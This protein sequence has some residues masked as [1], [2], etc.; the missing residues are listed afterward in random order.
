MLAQNAQNREARMWVAINMAAS[1]DG[2]IATKARGPVK[3]GSAQDSRRMAEIR[4]EHDAVINGASTFR[5]YPLPLSVEPRDLVD[6]RVSAG[7]SAQP[8]SAVVSS[9]LDI[10]RATKWEKAREVE[11]WI[12]CGKAAPEKVKRALESSGVRVIRSKS[13]RPSAKEILSAFTKAGCKK[14]LLEGGGEFNAAFLEKGLVN[15]I[16]LT[17]APL[18]I[19][20]AESITFFEGKGFPRGKFPRFRLQECKEMNGELFLTYDRV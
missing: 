7:R 5:A 18:L 9:R 15:R 19:G 12:F 17:V 6:A 8:I 4:A 14:L 20:G 11:R 13:A 2:K 1:I 16:Y 3:L 10:P